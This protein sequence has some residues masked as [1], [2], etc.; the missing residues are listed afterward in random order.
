MSTGQQRRAPPA[1]VLVV[2][3]P[4]GITSFEVVGR[5]RRILGIKRV[6]HT[7]T[8]DPLATGVLPL[9]LGQATKIAGLLL[10]EDKAYRGT[11]LLGL[12]TDTLDV[13]GRVLQ[14]R[15]P[16]AVTRD[17]V[18]E[19]LARLRGP[20]LQ[21]PPAFSAVRKGGRRAHELAR[22]GQQVE[23]E[24]RPVEV[25][26]LEL[27]RWEPPRLELFVECSKGTYVRSLVADL[28]RLLG[29]GA[30]LEQLRRLRSGSFGLEQAVGLED[31]EQIWQGGEELPLT[32]MDRALC[33]L[34]AV[35]LSPQEV[36]RVRQG[37]EVSRP[38]APDADLARLRLG[39]ELVALG[40]V[41]GGR[42]RPKRVFQRPC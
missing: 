2:D 26:R 4:A 12:Q 28:G 18:L 8:L 13:T 9:C 1:A 3:K 5:V 42:V 7:G 17:G 25:L 39:P 38:E 6:G 31:L 33:H 11:A 14:R 29:C 40:R 23:L 10:A 22:A 35:E 30:A 21:V 34:P 19:A 36:P 37:Q 20:Q 24:P 16:G 27:E 32:S 41:E 15:D